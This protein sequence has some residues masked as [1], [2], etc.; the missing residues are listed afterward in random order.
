MRKTTVASVRYAADRID[1][2]IHFTDDALARLV[3]VPRVFLPTALKGCIKWAKENGVTEITEKEMII[4][5]DKRSK[6]KNK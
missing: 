1:P 2:S 3:N 6:E 5:N 4:I